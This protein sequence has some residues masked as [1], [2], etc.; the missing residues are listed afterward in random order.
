MVDKEKDTINKVDLYKGWLYFAALGVLFVFITIFVL[1]KPFLIVTVLIC[2]I[3]L[4]GLFLRNFYR[5]FIEVQEYLYAQSQE[6]Q[7]TGLKNRRFF[8]ERIKELLARYERDGDNF[9][10]VFFDLDNFK[11]CNSQYGHSAGDQLL[12]DVAQFLESCTRE[13]EPLARFGGDE[14][15]LLLPGNTLP[16]AR[17]TAERIRQELE[18]KIFEVKEKQL[19]FKLSGGVAVCPKDGTDLEQLL[20]TADSNM[21]QAK[22]KGNVICSSV[23]APEQFE[24]YPPVT[25]NNVDDYLDKV[26]KQTTQLH[27]LAKSGD[28]EVIRQSIVG[29]K[30]F[31]LWGERGVFEFYYILEGEIFH[32][33]EERTLT[34]GTSIIVRN[35]AGE[36]YFKTKT[37]CTLLYVTTTPV[38][39][40]EQR[41]IRE[42]ISLNKKVEIKDL[43]TEEHCTRLQK[44]SRRTGEKLGLKEEEMFA[45]DYASF[46][47]DIGKAE[48]STGI[49]RKTTKLDNE[50][51]ELMKQHSGWGRELILKH[52][53]RGSF[54][55]VADIVFQHHER[56]DGSGYPQG[57]SEDQILIE[58]QILSVVDSYDAMTTDRPYQKARIRDVALEEV[59]K[60]TGSQFA[61]IVVEA[62]LIAEEEEY[63]SKKS[64]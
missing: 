32:T 22:E 1:E 57:L 28:L 60:N 9:A 40:N 3:G 30:V 63:N 17:E 42:L 18:E 14:F 10:I 4:M 8:K 15:V 36:V 46:L 21:H 64:L 33:G 2:Y 58:A 26:G 49:L 7:L 50:E 24:M 20:G 19:S 53:K 43:Q 44:L 59:K 27:L 51:W 35:L 13:Q 52:L 45:L 6:D 29:D 41:H 5:K 31:R 62:F 12:K 54:E 37:D 16:E 48:I 38:F 61:P 23:E 56:Y 47:H 39:K 25:I 55:K 34:P 11:N